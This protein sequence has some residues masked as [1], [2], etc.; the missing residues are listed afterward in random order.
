MATDFVLDKS[1]KYLNKDFRSFKSDLIKFS[2][3]HHSGVFQ[4]FNE[5][6]PGMAILELQSFVG[7]VLAFYIDQNFNE[8]RDETSRQIESIVSNAKSRGYRP[9]GKRA[10]SG[11]ESFFIEVPA[12]TQLGSRVPDDLYSPILRKGAK[13]GGPNGTIFETLDDV[14]FSASSPSDNRFV[15]GSRFD[16]TTG[17]PTFFAIRKDVQVVAG[18]TKTFSTSVSDFQQFFQVELP[19]SD[20]IEIISVFDSDGNEWFEVNYLAQET[21]FDQTTNVNDD[22]SIVPYVLRLKTVPRR[23]I[24]DRDPTTNKTSIIFGSGDGISFDDELVPNLADLSLPLAGRRTFSSFSLDPQN[25]LRTRTLGL[26]PVNTT[27]TVSY[28]VGG[29]PQTNVPP[30][31]IKSVNEAVLDFSSTGLDVAKKS[32]VIGSLE[33]TNVS[34]TDGGAPEESVAEIKANSAAFFA[35]QNRVV[36]REDVIARVLSLPARF[37]KP[38]KVTVKRDTVSLLAFDLHLLAKDPDGHLTQATSTLK[39]N[40]STYLSQFRM[41]TDGIN[42]LESDIINLGVQFGVVTSPKMNKVQVLAACLQTIQ[43]YFDIDRWQ[44]GQPI[45]ISD[46]QSRIQDVL[47]VISVYQLGFRNIVGLQ[48]NGLSYSQVTFDVAAATSNNILY[49]PDNSIFEVKNPVKDIVGESK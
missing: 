8:L 38:E 13:I 17:L 27:I 14:Q 36:T 37:G 6:S 43:D 35:A 12:T 41:L 48:S 23:F 15:T 29:G 47:G 26:S 18:E 22:N 33:C 21:V 40:I 2:Q 20:V 11:V 46:L 45:I 9:S 16:S 19:E 30:G 3:A 49:C 28:R 24:S 1:V 42:I 10:A 25:F 4:D 31:S 44:I 39:N 32:S 34:R 7:D 5:S